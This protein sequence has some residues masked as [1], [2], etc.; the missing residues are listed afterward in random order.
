LA[1]MIGALVNWVRPKGRIRREQGI[2]S[3]HIMSMRHRSRRPTIYLGAG[4]PRDVGIVFGR[5]H[6]DVVTINDDPELLSQDTNALLASLY[7]VNGVL[8][9]QDELLSTAVAHSQPR[10]R[11][12]GIVIIPTSYPIAQVIRLTHLL[13]RWYQAAT[14]SNPFG[15]RNRLLYPGEDGLHVLDTT[16]DLG[17]RDQLSFPWAW[18]ET[19]NDQLQT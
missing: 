9:T 3:R 8:V 17:S 2:S 18:W 12:A 6:F 14:I 1:A 11:H 10:L 16:T 15:G 7:Q 4:I 13:A 5:H 19:D